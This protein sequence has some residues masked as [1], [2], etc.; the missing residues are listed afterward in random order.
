MSKKYFDLTGKHALVTAA[1]T[2]LAQALVNALS[3]AGAKVSTM[4]LRDDKLELIESSRILKECVT[5]DLQGQ[6]K[7][8][9]LTQPTA[10]E[11]AI[12]ELQGDIAPIDILVNGAH[13]A[14]IQP[15]LES[16]VD[17]WHTMINLNATSTF[18]ASH[19]VGRR[20][21]A[22]GATGR[23]V[24]LVSIVHDRGVP[25]CALFGA[26][27]GAV[28]GFT[29]S[30]GLEWGRQGVN[31]NAIGVGFIDGLAGPHNDKELHAILQKTIPA[32][33]TGTT[34]D[35][36]GVVVYLASD[37]AG[38]VNAEVFTVDG[39]MQTHG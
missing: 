1:T 39:A 19:A 9:D 2:P 11:S 20:I 17:D 38:F 26:S 34:E 12:D 10:V 14:R 35:L 33:R 25:N 5:A 36:K 21:I 16:T 29:K 13:C 18:V 3:E 28:L 23:I 24:N 4:T 8:V 32:R 22:R 37:E 30:L 27:Q 15:M 7:C 6:T 31:V